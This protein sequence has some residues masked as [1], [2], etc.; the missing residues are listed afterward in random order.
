MSLVFDPRRKFT[1]IVLG[2]AGMD[3]YPLPDGGETEAAECFAAEVGGSAGNIAVALARQGHR[4]ALLGAFSDDAVGR[5]VRQH[6]H[7]Y[8]VDTSRCPSLSGI[9]RTS[10]AICETRPTDTE[11]VFY[12]NHAVD[13]QLST[14]DVDPSFIAD[15]SFLV[16]TGTA[17]TTE[18]SRAAALCAIR[19]A[20]AANVCCILDL[21]YRPVSGAPREETRR[22]LED[23]AARCNAV[24][25]NEEEFAVLSEISGG[26][27]EA[28]LR[29][30]ETTC[31]LVIYKKGA[32][33]S[34]TISRDGR[35]QSGVIAVDAKKPFGA[36][37]AFLGNLLV[38]LHGGASLSV[39]VERASAAA[40]Y[41]VARRGCAFSMPTSAELNGFIARN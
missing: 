6:L 30:V 26:G 32:A 41:V 1:A 35:F 34:I 20:R 40:A 33:G 2:R 11:T 25:G 15:A 21:D 28:A 27:F 10:L 38:A 23:A 31:E 22:V 3:L 8:G 14:N 13:L 4:A 19:Y 18:P 39:S 29:L 16:V 17:L 12:R 37:D 9:F 24:I 5:F 36:G 7:R